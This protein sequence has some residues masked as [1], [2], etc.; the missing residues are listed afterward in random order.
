MFHQQSCKGVKR[1]Y[2]VIGDRIRNNLESEIC[3]RASKTSQTSSSVTKDTQKHNKPLLAEMNREP[4]SLGRGMKKRINLIERG[5]NLSCDQNPPV[6]L[7]NFALHTLNRVWGDWLM[8]GK[9]A[10]HW[11][12][13][14]RH[15]Q[16][17]ELLGWLQ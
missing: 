6:L 8:E 2:N 12:N 17:K 15:W 11:N 3:F 4:Y 7:V 9:Q 14:P 13:L 10:R 16:A 1:Q 5:Q